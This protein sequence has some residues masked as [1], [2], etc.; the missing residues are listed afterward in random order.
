[1]YGDLEEIAF[2][3]QLLIE[4]EPKFGI[5]KAKKLPKESNSEI[6]RWQNLKRWAGF[7]GMNDVS[8]NDFI[9]EVRKCCF[10]FVFGYLSVEVLRV[11]FRRAWRFFSSFSRK[12]G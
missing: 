4:K 1:M 3:T 7:L 9:H 2:R 8:T 12:R 5:L 11:W 10:F 6:S